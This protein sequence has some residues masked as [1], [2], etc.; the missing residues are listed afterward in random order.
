MNL[1]RMGVKMEFIGSNMKSM[2]SNEKVMGS[3]DKMV[4]IASQSNPNFELMTKNLSGF[5]K[6]MD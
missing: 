6:C 5:E 4:Q 3:F 1:Q 2:D